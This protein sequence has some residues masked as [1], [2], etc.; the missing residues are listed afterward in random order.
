MDIK[1]QFGR[2]PHRA[3]KVRAEREAGDKMPI[4]DIDMY[5]VGPGRFDR[6]EILAET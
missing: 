4:H 2:S 6:S 5:R 3:D 1:R